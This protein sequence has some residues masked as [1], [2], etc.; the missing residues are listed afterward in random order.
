[1][2]WPRVIDSQSSGV[3]SR[4]LEVAFAAGGETLCDARIQTSL[5]PC[6]VGLELA[7]QGGAASYARDLAAP[8]LQAGELNR[9]GDWVQQQS[10]IWPRLLK[11][12]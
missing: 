3:T 12:A 7:Q 1:M 2:S 8:Q 9:L 6:P 11:P 4:G 10:A 5:G